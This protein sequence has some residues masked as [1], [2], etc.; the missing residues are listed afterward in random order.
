M[1]GIA[2]IVSWKGSTLDGSRIRRM[3]KAMAHRGPDAEGLYEEETMALG[4]LR[5]AIIDLSSDANQPF[6]DNSGRY[7]LI[8]NGEIYNYK[9]VKKLLPDFGEF[10]RKIMI[11]RQNQLARIVP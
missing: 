2:G 5:L 7:L 6:P 10:R 11:G 3:T 1:C 4:H 9:E 8:F